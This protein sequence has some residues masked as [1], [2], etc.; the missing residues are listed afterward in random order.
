[1]EPYISGIVLDKTSST[2]EESD[3]RLK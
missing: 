2:T 3:A 1:M